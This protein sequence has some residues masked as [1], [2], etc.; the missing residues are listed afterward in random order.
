VLCLVLDR[1][2]ALTAAPERL[3]AL[4]AQGVDLVQL[5]EREVSGGALLGLARQLRDAVRRAGG[6]IALVVNR[7]ADVA[8]A[9][10]ADGVH[11]GFDG[12]APRDAR[13]L[14]GEA[15]LIGVSCHAPAEVAAAEGASYAHLAPIF[16][17]LSKAPS[18]APLGPAA[19]SACAGRP[20]L[21]QGG[22]TAETAGACLA[23]G[24]AGVAVT[25]AILNAP[26]PAAAA[27]RLRR[28]LDAAAQG[29]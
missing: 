21:A 18:R 9:A 8:L 16:P 5:R 20:V 13:E 14:L 2:A 10:G 22:I 4:L 29:R 11:L 26:D 25:G 17:P 24:A 19:L 23:A 1:A 27:A 3:T 15:A 28:A 7:R 12:L 6:A